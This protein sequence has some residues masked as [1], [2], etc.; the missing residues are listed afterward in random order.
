MSESILAPNPMTASAQG[1]ARGSESRAKEAARA[2]ADAPAPTPFADVLKS[3]SE[4]PQA[5]S[6][7]ETPNATEPQAADA[8]T[9]AAELAPAV[10]SPQS[11][12]FVPA[13]DTLAGPSLLEV[14]L[15]RTGL[16]TQSALAPDASPA[17][18]GQAAA[19]ILALAAPANPTG[20]VSPAPTF[21]NVQP[22][23]AAQGMVEQHPGHTADFAGEH[24]TA[25]DKLAVEAAIA[26]ASGTA[27]A[28]ATNRDH[29][30]GEFRAV[31]ERVTNN[32]VNVLMQNSGAAAAAPTAPQP[33]LR[34][35]TPLTHAAWPDE[36][37][38]KLTWMANNHR[39]QAELV[40][41]P[42]QLGRIEVT[43]DLTGD[44]ASVSFV[45]PHAA[46][47]ETLEASL[48]RLREV[49]A[50]AGV[51]LGQTH[52]GADSRHNPNSMYL[53]DDGSASGRMDGDRR[54]ETPGTLRSGS[55]GLSSFGR[56]MVD[57][58]A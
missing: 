20:T 24:G 4:K 17:V 38:Q 49:L 27:G 31:M 12:A 53:K 40:L 48:A 57:I 13:I 55:A 7:R 22:R 25:T 43:L 36:M 32:P 14:D 44:Q 37:G 10:P 15:P 58:F 1:S 5:E 35:E 45:S 6:A 30:E 3:R 16:E 47:R 8:A 56:G 33:G 23:G 26:A 21:A 29:G 11:L 50:E 39:Q 41:N 19:L 54:V 18:Q 34:L 2:D 51:T 42:P 9:T 52:V 28:S 46:V